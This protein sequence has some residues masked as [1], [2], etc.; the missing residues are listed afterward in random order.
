[1]NISV[2]LSIEAKE[3]IKRQRSWY[4]Q[5]GAGK[6]AVR[7]KLNLSRAIRIRL[8]SE[9]RLH[10]QDRFNAD[11]RQLLVEGFAISY[12]I[13][14]SAAGNIYIQVDRVFGPGQNRS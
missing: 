12:H 6:Q 7:K 2:I 8:Q 13:F 9:F 14:Q 11:N 4:S 3:D 1:M 5:V 10:K